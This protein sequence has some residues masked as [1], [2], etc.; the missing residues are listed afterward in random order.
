MHRVGDGVGAG[1]GVQGCRGRPRL[2]LHGVGGEHTVWGPPDAHLV[3]MR[4]SR[5]SPSA[6]GSGTDLCLVGREPEQAGSWKVGG[7]EDRNHTAPRGRER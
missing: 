1:S 4:L 7:S 2:A 6:W 3:H 5:C